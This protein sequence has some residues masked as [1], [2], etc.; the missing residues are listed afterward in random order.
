M[1]YSMYNNECLLVS[2]SRSDDGGASY[3]SRLNR[4]SSP[5]PPIPHQNFAPPLP[6]QSPSRSSL[7]NNL[8][9]VAYDDSDSL[10]ESD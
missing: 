8:R 5:P 10:N 1:Y 2:G 3:Y 4:D 9:G 7:V 6:N